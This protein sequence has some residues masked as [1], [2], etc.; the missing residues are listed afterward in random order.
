LDPGRSR[1][2]ADSTFEQSASTDHHLGRDAALL[3][4]GTAVAGTAIA[5]RG[6][7]SPPGHGEHRLSLAEEK[8]ALV[9]SSSYPVSPTPPEEEHPANSPTPYFSPSATQSSRAPPSAVPP[10]GSPVKAQLSPPPTKP[11]EFRQ[12]IAMQSPQQ[13]IQSFDQT[14]HRWANMESGLTD[15]VLK[16]QAQY[17]EH[18]NASSSWAG[19]R[20]S[21]PSGSSRSKFAKNSGGGAPPLQ[22]P[23]YRQYLNASPTT[24]STPTRPGP[25][26]GPSLQSGS[27]QGFSSAGNKLSSQQ[28]QAKGKELL[29]S[30][31]IFGGKAGKAGKGL[32]AKGKNKLRGAGGGDKVD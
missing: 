24:P 16:L 5:A 1:E 9:S 2:G 32:L 29:H 27:Q 22:E 23:Y 7:Q 21:A 18:A 10:V 17:P 15:W 25:G 13:R 8:D 11:L 6:P 14:R 20:M 26:P 31:G 30:A 3:A 4:G 28:V 19:S 12:I